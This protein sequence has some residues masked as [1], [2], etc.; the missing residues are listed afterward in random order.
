MQDLSEKY[1]AVGTAEGSGKGCLGKK[2]SLSS[3]EAV[4]AG[5][6]AGRRQ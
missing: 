4:G 6:E 1:E 3:F 2:G 5:R